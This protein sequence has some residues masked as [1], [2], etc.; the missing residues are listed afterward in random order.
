MLDSVPTAV[1][2]G[3]HL[4]GRTRAGQNGGNRAVW[5]ETVRTYFVIGYIE[6]LMGMRHGVPA[7]RLVY[8]CCAAGVSCED[9]ARSSL[10]H[11]HEVLRV[12]ELRKSHTENSPIRGTADIIR[13]ARCPP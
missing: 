9:N 13:R 5:K 4:F 3:R 10:H 11:Q 12:V 1:G 8:V 6:S 7:G 2:I